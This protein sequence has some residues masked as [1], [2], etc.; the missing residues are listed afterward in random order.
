MSLL[1]TAYLP[2]GQSC[3]YKTNSSVHVPL[4]FEAGAIYRR[5]STETCDLIRK[6]FEKSLKFVSD[7]RR[8]RVP[9]VT[10]DAL[11]KFWKKI[12]FGSLC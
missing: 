2:G 4:I 6:I 3:S 1:P 12:K 5:V 10:G 8:W 7:K 11:N 9:R